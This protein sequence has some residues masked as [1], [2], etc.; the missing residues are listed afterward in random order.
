MSFWKPRLKV[1]QSITGSLCGTR[2]NENYTRVI[3]RVHSDWMVVRHICGTKRDTVYPY[4]FEKIKGR[5]YSDDWVYIP[6][7]RNWFPLPIS[8]KFYKWTWKDYLWLILEHLRP[9]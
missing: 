6:R 4:D 3:T 5:L 9:F 7:N 1:G 2:P 8:P